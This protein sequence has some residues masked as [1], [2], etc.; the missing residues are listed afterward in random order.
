VTARSIRLLLV[1][2]HA[3]I[4]EGLKAALAAE[5]DLEVAGEA[6]N[7]ADALALLE[8]KRFDVALLDVGLPDKSGF[9]LLQRIKSDLPEMKVLVLSSYPE[10]EYGPQALR[11]GADG[12][13]N[14]GLAPELVAKAIR[15]VAAGGQYLSPAL[16]KHLGGDLPGS[17][18]NRK[19]GAQALS[20]RERE[21]LQLL[22]SGKSATE[23]GVALHLSVKTVSTYRSRILQKTGVASNAELVRYALHRGIIS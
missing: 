17:R 2:D 6:G 3:L 14:K 12:F 8:R 22:V 20:A 4:R 18:A 5:P 21:V 16:F 7:V 19:S 1:D 15:V 13:L 11:D 10:Q 23:I 9:T